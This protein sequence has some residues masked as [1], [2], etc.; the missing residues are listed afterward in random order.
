MTIFCE[1]FRGGPWPFLPAPG[2]ACASGCGVER[3]AALS[4]VA[5]QRLYFIKTLTPEIGP[6]T[7]RAHMMWILSVLERLVDV[8][9]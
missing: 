1:N 9:S 4:I 7:L 3:Y 8:F 5:D 6:Q 2:Y